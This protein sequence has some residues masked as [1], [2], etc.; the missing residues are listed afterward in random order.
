[1]RGAGAVAAERAKKLRRDQTDVERKL[2][3][4]LRDRRLGGKKFRRQVPIGSYIVD[5][6]C[7]EQKLIV[8]LDGG[9]HGEQAAYDDRRTDFLSGEGYRVLRFWNNDAI[10]NF[11]GVLMTIAEALDR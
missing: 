9:Q 7:L 4:A 6:L 8:E 3:L 1:V 11:D 2:W 5:F 10:E